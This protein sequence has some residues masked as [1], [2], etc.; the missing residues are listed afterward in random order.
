MDQLFPFLGHWAWWVAA[1]V[2]LIIE[3]V[4]PGV[5]FI[6]LGIA[7]ALTGLADALFDLPWQAEA[8]LFAALPC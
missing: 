8:L 3:L 1:G 5:F 4:A 2:L 6:W 7:A